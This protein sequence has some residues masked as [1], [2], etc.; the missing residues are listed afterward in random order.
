MTEDLASISHVVGYTK[1]VFREDLFG[2]DDPM[3]RLPG[4]RIGATGIDP[5]TIERYGARL[6]LPPGKLRAGGAS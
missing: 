3:L 5:L 6:V 4:A 2:D 1:R